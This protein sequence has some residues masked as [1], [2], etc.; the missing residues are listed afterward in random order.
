MA[1]EKPDDKTSRMIKMMRRARGGRTLPRSG[2][3][4]HEDK[5]SKKIERQ[6]A[7]ESDNEM[8]KFITGYADDYDL[9]DDIDEDDWDEWVEWDN[10]KFPPPED[11][12]YELEPSL[13]KDK[14]KKDVATDR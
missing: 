2:G 10:Y 14:E 9:E 13:S 1:R 6:L 11:D 5:K 3:G 8:R 7:E 12:D 4:V